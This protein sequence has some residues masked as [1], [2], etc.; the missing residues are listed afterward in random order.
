MKKKTVLV[1]MMERERAYL[2]AQEVGTDEYNKS[3]E[4]LRIL[5]GD[6]SRLNEEQ[7]DRVIRIVDMA[8]K[9]TLVLGGTYWAY[10]FEEKGT[11]TTTVGR[12]IMKNFI[13][14]L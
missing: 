1:E 2:E 7:K 4:R 5:A 14:K 6:V 13:P 11:I 8:I 12:G 10:R 9:T 3:L